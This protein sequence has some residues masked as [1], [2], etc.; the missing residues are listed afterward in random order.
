MKNIKFLKNKTMEKFDLNATKVEDIDNYDDLT[1]YL[2]TLD[3]PVRYEYLLK[4]LYNYGVKFDTDTTKIN[5]EK[6]FLGKIFDEYREKN[7]LTKYVLS[8]NN[9][10]AYEFILKILDAY[11]MLEGELRT[12]LEKFLAQKS[13]NKY[14]NKIMLWLDDTDENVVSLINGKKIMRKMI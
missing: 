7:E 8:L 9:I 6:F 5:S 1:N 3:R 11:N 12:I 10:D 4:E 2:L 14:R 13:F